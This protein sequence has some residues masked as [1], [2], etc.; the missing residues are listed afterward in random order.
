MKNSLDQMNGRLETAGKQV[1]E[2]EN[3]AVKLTKT[4]HSK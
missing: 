1:S 4:K 3:T 2:H